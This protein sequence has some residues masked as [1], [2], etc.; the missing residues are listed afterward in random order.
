MIYQQGIIVAHSCDPGTWEGRKGDFLSSK[1]GYPVLQSEILS[2]NEKRNLSK[3][4]K[5]F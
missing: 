2:Q 1:A 3:G 4:K 5:F